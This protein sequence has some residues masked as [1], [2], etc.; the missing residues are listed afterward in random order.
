[1]PNE[2]AQGLAKYKPEPEYAAKLEKAKKEFSKQAKSGISALSAEFFELKRRKAEVE[3]RLSEFNLKI[4]AVELLMLKSLEDEDLTKVS[5]E[6][7]GT[8]FKKSTAYPVVKDKKALFDWIKK[9]K[10]VALLSVN[11]QTL[12][13]VVNDRLRE[14]E[15]LPGGVDA[16]LKD[17]IGHRGGMG[18]ESDD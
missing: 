1:M 14:G 11:H 9:N 16:F 12:K 8:I 7:G 18:E 17:S 15:D 6:G 10:L 13:S 5:L 3:K 4:A 2:T